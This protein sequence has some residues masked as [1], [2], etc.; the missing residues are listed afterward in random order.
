MGNAEGIGIKD[1]YY[2]QNWKKESKGAQMVLEPSTDGLAL[3]Q[4]Y[5]DDYGVRAR[6]LKAREGRKI[7]GYLSVLAPVEIM[8]AAGVV[9]VRLKG[10]ISED[11]TRG[12][13]SMQGMV[14]PFIR[15]VFD[16]TLKDEYDF[17]DGMVI[18]HLCN[19]IDQ[20]NDNWRYK[21]ALPY[22]HCLNVPHATDEPSLECMRETLR[23]FLM[24]LEEFVGHKITDVA[25]SY[26]ITSHWFDRRLMRRL[27][28]LRKNQPPLISGTELMKVLVAAMSVP[29][30]ESSGLIESVIAQVERRPIKTEPRKRIMLIGAQIDDI[31]IPQA[32]EEAGAWL[33]MDDISI[34]SKMYWNDVDRTGDML[35]AIADR[36]LRKLKIPMVESSR[37]TSQEDLEARFG[38]IR[39]HVEDFKVDGVILLVCKYCYSYGLEAP[40]IRRYI[41]SFGTPVLYMEDEY[42]VSSL[43]RLKSNIEAFLGMI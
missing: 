21:L 19:S 15:N 9:P 32:I 43:G 2:L 28:D 10:N 3:A 5:Y 1:R 23:A 36:Y 27:Y 14:C 11:V 30:E 4:K 29:V 31:R 17:L 13:V 25:L 33:V 42:S 20:A 8:S 38:H 7:L 6:Q 39:G 37:E 34:G 22:W 16:T 40:V 24:S 26:A 41:E 12:D 35:L 18:P